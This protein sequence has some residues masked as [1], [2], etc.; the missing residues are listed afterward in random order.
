MPFQDAVN[1]DQ[2]SILTRALNEHCQTV[3][4]PPDSEERE[5]LAS[6]VFSLFRMGKTTLEELKQALSSDRA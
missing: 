1:P 4:I 3:G 6:R 2:L 5:N